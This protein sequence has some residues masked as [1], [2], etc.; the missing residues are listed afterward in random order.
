MLSEIDIRDYTEEQCQQALADLDR[1]YDFLRPIN[2]NYT[3]E[4]DHVVNCVLWLE[5]RLKTL[6]YKELGER[7]LEGRL[8]SLALNQKA[9]MTPRGRADNV[10]EAAKLMGY[11]QQTIRTYLVT[12]SEEYYR[13]P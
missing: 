13:C 6:M 10:T 3:P 9:V 7:G 8:A 1:E 11:S 4:I 5:D 2:N 12:K